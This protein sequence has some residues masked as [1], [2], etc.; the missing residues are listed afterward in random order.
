M[1]LPL[2]LAS[3]GFVLVATVPGR[4][5]AQGASGGAQEQPTATSPKAVVEQL[6][7]AFNRRD[8]QAFAAL[9]ADTIVTHQIGGTAVHRQSRADFLNDVRKFV[10]ANPQENRAV[11][12]RIVAGRFVADHERTTGMADGRSKEGIDVFEVRDGH[13]VSEWETPLMPM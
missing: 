11:V 13:I 2:R 1:K 7:D 6:G 12:N 5:L 3:L 10:G 8:W 9:V 4:G